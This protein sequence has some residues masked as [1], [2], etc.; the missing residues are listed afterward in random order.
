MG[1]V[2]RKRSDTSPYLIRTA[3]T[4]VIVDYKAAGPY[5]DGMRITPV[6]EPMYSPGEV[7]D[8][9]V[10]LLTHTSA[11]TSDVEASYQEGESA[12]SSLPGLIL[13]SLLGAILWVGLI[14]TGA[15]LVR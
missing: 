12:P 5:A 2:R 1:A 13:G 6:Q 9:P 3:L 8:E 4:N 14:L 15:M 11:S 7:V 10:V